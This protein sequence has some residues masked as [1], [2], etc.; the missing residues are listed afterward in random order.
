MAKMP[1]FDVKVAVESAN[2]YF[3]TDDAYN[4]VPAPAQQDAAATPA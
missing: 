4:G 1:A 2:S 3:G